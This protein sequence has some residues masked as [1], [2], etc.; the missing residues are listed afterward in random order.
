MSVLD[1]IRAQATA[2]PRVIDDRCLACPVCLARKVCRSKAL[3]R[4]DPDE[5]PFVDASRCYGCRACIPACP[6]DAIVAC[7]DC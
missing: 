5:P 2:I 6:N 4:L 1:T 3:I 7:S